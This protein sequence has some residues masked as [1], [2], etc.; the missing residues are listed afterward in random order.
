MLQWQVFAE[1]PN[2]VMTL[3]TQYSGSINW[4]AVDIA[5]YILVSVTELFTAKAKKLHQRY[6]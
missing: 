3:A 2:Y 1:S 4:V 6:I 5:S